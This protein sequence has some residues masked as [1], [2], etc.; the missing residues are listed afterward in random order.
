MKQIIEW[1]K[2]PKNLKKLEFK[3]YLFKAKKGVA[4]P[5]VISGA[6]DYYSPDMDWEYI[7][8]VEFDRTRIWFPISYFTHYAE[9]ED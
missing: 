4:A 1:K 2:I 5:R 8:V 6:L 3:D 7:V 9:V